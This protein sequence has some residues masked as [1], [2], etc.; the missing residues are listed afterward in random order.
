MISGNKY[1]ATDMLEWGEKKNTLVV[2][3]KSTMQLTRKYE[4]LAYHNYIQFLK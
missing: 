3:Q 1:E 2:L 4:L